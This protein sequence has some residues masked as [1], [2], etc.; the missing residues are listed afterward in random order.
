MVKTTFEQAMEKQQKTF[1][2]SATH[3]SNAT[4]FLLQLVQSINENTQASDIECYEPNA[5][6][7][8]RKFSNNAK[9][10]LQ[11][12]KYM[13][14]EKKVT[15][16]LEVKPDASSTSKRRIDTDDTGISSKKAKLDGTEQT[17]LADT[18]ATEPLQ[19]L[20]GLVAME[21]LEEDAVVIEPLQKPGKDAVVIEPLQ[22]PGKAKLDGARL[23]EKRPMAIFDTEKE[24]EKLAGTAETEPLAKEDGTELAEKLEGTSKTVTE[25]MEE[26][27]ADTGMTEKPPLARKGSSFKIVDLIKEEPK[28]Q[29]KL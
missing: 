21:N 25:P 20:E 7:A 6:D 15:E 3:L 12:I 9:S 18:A 24:T 16:K 19:D 4:K 13:V 17:E 2:D 27:P 11:F 1:A 23:A 14:T 8:V 26:N 5:I 29:K 10:L 28:Q 22:K